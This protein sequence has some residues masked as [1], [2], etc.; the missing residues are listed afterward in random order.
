MKGKLCLFL[1]LAGCL[2]GL[3]GR[4]DLGGKELE[5]IAD[6]LVPVASA[7]LDE[8]DLVD[9]GLLVRR[10]MLVS[11]AG[12]PMPLPCPTG[13]SWSLAASKRSQTSV[14]PGWWWP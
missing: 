2:A 7:L 9:A 10:E 11:S 14:R 8:H 4:H 1:R 3:Q 5:R 13:G 12:V 6:M